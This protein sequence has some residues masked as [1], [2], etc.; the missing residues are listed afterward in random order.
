MKRTWVFL[1]FYTCLSFTLYSQPAKNHR[2]HLGERLVYEMEYGWFTLGQAEVVLDETLYTVD[3]SL[4]YKTDIHARTLG[5][6]RLFEGIEDR[7][8]GLVSVDDYRSIRSEKHLVRKKGLWDQWNFFNYDS[9]KVSVRAK[10]WGDTSPR[11]WTVDLTGDTYDIPGTYLYLRSQDWSKY[12][13]GDSLM[14]KTFYEKKLYEFGV[15][16][17]GTEEVTFNDIPHTAQILHMLFPVSGTFPQK[18][19]V[20][21]WVINY[22]DVNLPVRLEAQTKFGKVR[23]FLVAFG[24][25]PLTIYQE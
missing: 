25:G 12:K 16:H 7:F 24:I 6:L 4:Y 20:T 22:D 11:F 18:R 15:E 13:P 19:A 3:G 10:E 8:S 14:L 5:L 17:G 9:M 2:F 21:I 1:G 23:A